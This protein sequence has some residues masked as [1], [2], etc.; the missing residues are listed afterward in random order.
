MQTINIGRN[1]DGQRLD[2]ILHRYLP[3]AGTGFIYKMLR[4]KNIVLNDKKAE[5]DERLSAGDVVRLYLSDDTI[6]AFG[7]APDASQNVSPAASAPDLPV[8]QP[9]SLRDNPISDLIIYEDPDIIL[10]NKPVGMLSQKAEPTDVSLNE[11]I[12]DHLMAKGEVSAQSL[13]TF[14]PSVCN[15]LD[16]NTSGIVAAGK[17]LEGSRVLS[18]LFKDRSIE[19]YYLCIVKGT[20]LT[21][22]HVKGYL[23]KDEKNNR[24]TVKREKSDDADYIETAFRPVADDGSSTL[25]EVKLITGKT[26]QIRAHLAS[27]GHPIA[28]DPKYGDVQYNRRVRDEHR[29]KHQLLFAYRLVFPKDMEKLPH[30][31]GREF[32][33]KKPEAFFI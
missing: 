11:Y 22:Q 28:G 19:K 33:L 1:E 14:R 12:I 10:V 31:A 7:G 24:V 2:R 18:Q 21:A 23:W 15:R 5:G 32:V 25:L 9:G 26:H 4:K 27:I 8:K 17:S 6:A 30:L 16:R 13:K 20:G 29:V 3:T